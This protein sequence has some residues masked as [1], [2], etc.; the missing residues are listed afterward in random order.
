MLGAPI[1]AVFVAAF[2]FSV[3]PER[4][5]ANTGSRR[6]SIVAGAFC[7]L[8]LP[9]V[10]ANELRPLHASDDSSIFSTDRVEMY[11]KDNPAVFQPYVDAV[12]LIAAY[13]PREVGLYAETT[14]YEYP[15]RV[16]LKERLSEM[17]G[18]S[19]LESR[20]LRDTCVRASMPRRSFCP[21][22]GNFG[23]MNFLRERRT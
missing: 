18:W 15:I 5:V 16:L 7:A 11:F 12:N 13:R 1:M 2:R 21:I 19:T 9:W 4:R 8:S 17:P 14:I 23:F 22:R 3:K 6:I 10:V 20:M